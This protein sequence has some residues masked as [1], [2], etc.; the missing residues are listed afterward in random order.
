MSDIHAK[1]CATIQAKGTKA[2]LDGLSRDDNPYTVRTKA[3][4]RWAKVW[5]DGYNQAEH[6][7]TCDVCKKWL[8]NARGYHTEYENGFTY[9]L[10]LTCG[11]DAIAPLMKVD[12]EHA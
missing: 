9:W 10:C 2:W 8:S 6:G 7:V 11:I 1:Q 3:G 12:N 4:K 5:L